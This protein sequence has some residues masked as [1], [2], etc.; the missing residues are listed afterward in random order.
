MLAPDLVERVRELLREKV[1]QREIARRLP[2]SRAS[3]MLIARGKDSPRP[4]PTP[5]SEST[6][7][8]SPFRPCRKRRCRQCGAMII[9]WPCLLCTLIPAE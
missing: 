9:L 8:P 7:G 6:E 4:K 1:P 2:I 5:D 3:V